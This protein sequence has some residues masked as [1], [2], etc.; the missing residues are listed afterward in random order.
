VE[1]AAILSNSVRNKLALVSMYGI[2]L[3]FLFPFELFDLFLPVFILE[4]MFPVCI[5]P[6]DVK[7]FPCLRLSAVDQS[8]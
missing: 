6:S 5:L 8:N 1:L 2:Y 7:K 3:T 4:Q